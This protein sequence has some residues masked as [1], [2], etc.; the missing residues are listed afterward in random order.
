MLISQLYPSKYIKAADLQGRAV[1]VTIVRVEVQEIA[2]GEHKPVVYFQNKDKGLVLNKTNS[3]NIAVIYGDDTDQWSGKEVE[4]FTAWVD[5]QGRSV[6]AVRVRPPSFNAQYAAPQA[7]PP[8]T[9]TNDPALQG[10][11]GPNPPPPASPDLN[12]E[13]PF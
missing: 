6:E 3:Q 2:T 4:L 9:S 10:P 7:P 13:I 12:D 8:P 5:F 1:Q 11:P